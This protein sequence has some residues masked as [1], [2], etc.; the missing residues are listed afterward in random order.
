M[1]MSDQIKDEKL[2][3][4]MNGEAAKISALSSGKLHKYEYLTGEDILPS[5]QEQVIEKT[6][7]T[8]SPLG[9]A[10]DK[11]IKTIEDQGKEQVEAL[12]NLKPIERSKAIKYDDESLEQKQET[13]NKLFDEKLG[14]IKELSREIDNKNLNYDFT[15]KDSGSINFTGYNVPFTLFMKIRDGD[16]SLKMVNK[17][18]KKKIKR[19]FGQIKTGNPDHKSG[20]QLYTIT[21]AKNLYD[22]RQKIIDLFN[23]YS[24]IKPEA[25]YKS[26]QNESKGKGIKILAHKQMLQRLPIALAQVKSGNNS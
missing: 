7:F 11:Q 23:S 10:F 20:K 22:S 16:I 3:Y 13:Y 1:T 2:Q 25:I 8:Y 26:K 24:K 18:Q 4:D 15:M 14:E 17:D 19:K 5:N 9:K 21:N 6:K 12:E